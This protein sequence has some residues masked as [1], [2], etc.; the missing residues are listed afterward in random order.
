MSESGD[1][2][3]ASGATGPEPVDDRAS[4]PRAGAGDSGA[5]DSGAE[6]RPRRRPTRRTWTIVF[7]A[8]LVVAFVLVGSF[9]KVPYV[10]LGP[11]PTYDTLGDVDGDHVVAIDG[12]RSYDAEGQLRMTTVSLN[13]DVTLFGALGLWIS[14]RYAVAPREEYFRPGQTDEEVRKENVEQFRS[15][16][17]NAEVAAL[18]TLG[19]PVKVVADQVVADS[20]ASRVLEPGD[21][22]V[23]VNGKRVAGRRD[24]TAALKNTRPGQQVDL[25]YR[26]GEQ[27]SRTVQIELARHPEGGKQG[28]VGVQPADRA[29]VPFTVDISLEDVG[30][31]SAGA[32]FAL[33]IVERLEQEDLI[34]GR[35]VAG[36]GEIDAQG[37]VGAIGGISFKVV[38]AEEDGATTFLVPERNCAEAVSAAP[39]GLRLVRVGTLDDAVSALRNL[40][41]GKPV[42]TCEG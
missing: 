34:D 12:E 2:K 9:V 26:R 36:T 10:A 41:D 3:S 15:S 28:F 39:E 21:Q 19:Y 29:D 24:V 32:M 20:P 8:V 31:P 30:G 23:S 4:A 22:L 14:G 7:S 16:Q 37:N 33:A 42:P 6:R 18:R 25:T 1:K 5:D 11:G 17:S 13:D 35:R 40:R 38:A 27:Q